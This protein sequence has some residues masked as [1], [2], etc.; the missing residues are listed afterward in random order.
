MAY[1]KEKIEELIH[2]VVSDVLLKEIKDPRIGF[3][4]VTKVE[5]SKDYSYAK[6]GISVLGNA[7]EMRK[8]LE[9]LKSSVGFIQH[10]V[11]KE[12]GMRQTPRIQFEL[13]PSMAEGIRMAGIIDNLDGV[14]E[15]DKDNSDSDETP[16]E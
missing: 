15:D 12:L 14:R 16:E 10:R 4:T 5:L 3:V 7:R 2:R 11:G 13:D 8:S 1:R 6:V 9:G